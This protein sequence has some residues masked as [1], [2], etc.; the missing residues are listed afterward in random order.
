M[1]RLIKDEVSTLTLQLNELQQRVDKL[2]AQRTFE[3]S[4]DRQPVSHEDLDSKIGMLE[5]QVKQLSTAFSVHNQKVEAEEREAKK[6]SV[7][8]VGLEE[9]DNENA[10]E[11][12]KKLFATRLDIQEPTFDTAN[13]LGR[14]QSDKHRPIKVKFSSLQEKSL[15]MERKQSLK[16]TGT[17]I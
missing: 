10:V 15:V 6:T 5:T 14:K 9:G 4:T 11:A 13:C 3:Q 17:Y 7:I 1:H 16:H 8:I 2:E 12:V